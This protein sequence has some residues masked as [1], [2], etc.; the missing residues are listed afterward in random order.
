MWINFQ[1][2]YEME[3]VNPPN[4]FDD[5]DAE[6]ESEFY[7]RPTKASNGDAPS[8]WF[9]N[10]VPNSPPQN[11]IKIISSGIDNNNTY[12]QSKVNSN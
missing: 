2:V 8:G 6:D 12:N 5:F 7:Y 11:K 3:G 4:G 1:N 10:N 9:S